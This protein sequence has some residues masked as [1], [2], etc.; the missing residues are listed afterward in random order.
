MNEYT[1]MAQYYDTLMTSGY[2]N[3]DT[4][5]ASLETYIGDG[6]R[7]LEIGVGTGLVVE[8]LN[9]RRPNCYLTGVDHTEAMLHIAKERVGESCQLVQADVTTMDLGQTFDVILSCGGVWFLIDADTELQLC[10]HIP[11]EDEDQAAF[12]NV[13]THLRPG[14]LLL[15][16]VQGVHKDYEKK[17]PG[18]VTYR[19]SIS[20][21][22]TLFQKEYHFEGPDDSAVQHNTF[23]IRHQPDMDAF[24]RQHRLAAL[25]K[26]TNGAF[27]AFRKD[28]P[29]ETLQG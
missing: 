20:W 18:G 22:G 4:L 5:A 15:L 13:L 24:L 6:D 26:T 29:A 10:S 23:R 8:Q 1:K 7:V 25:P 16:N 11:D 28:T 2:Y 27:H 12:G 19:Q 17:L 21:C 9:A 14:G 3:Y